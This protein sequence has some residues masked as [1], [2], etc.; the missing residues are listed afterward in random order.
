MF[1]KELTLNRLSA[2]FFIIPI[3]E[4]RHADKNPFNP[5]STCF[6]V[7]CT[8]LRKKKTFTTVS[9]NHSPS[10]RRND[11]PSYPFG[12]VRYSVVGRRFAFATPREFPLTF[13]CIR[14]S[15]QCLSRA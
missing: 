10:S 9:C 11:L 3:S 4:Q 2:S 5:Q 6:V 12:F 8:F 14:F 13:T 7:I 1:F 15:P